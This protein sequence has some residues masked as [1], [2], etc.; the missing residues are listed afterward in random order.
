MN[1]R[2]CTRSTVLTIGISIICVVVIAIFQTSIAPF[3]QATNIVTGPARLDCANQPSTATLPEAIDLTVH[4]PKENPYDAQAQGNPRQL[5]G[6]TVKIQR[7]SDATLTDSE[8]LHANYSVTTAL[9]GPSSAFAETISVVTNADGVAHSTGLV[10]GLYLLS[11]DSPTHAD[12]QAAGDAT[13][14]EANDAH[15]Q[16]KRRIVDIEPQLVILP[17]IGEECLWNEAVEVYAKP[18]ASAAPSS[19]AFPGPL[20]EN[21]TGTQEH[22]GSGFSPK[23]S[24]ARTGANSIAVIVIGLLIAALGA[25]IVFTRNRTNPKDRR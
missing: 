5:D 20:G 11:V 10:P 16:P 14:D 17:T 8:K 22:V 19:V 24:L 25:F 6:Y 15:P 2:L 1:W 12:V 13:Y 7:F 21:P 18:A 4:L 9:S 3:V 23:N